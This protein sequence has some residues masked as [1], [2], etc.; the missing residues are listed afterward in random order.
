M[1]RGYITEWELSRQAGGLLS[2]EGDVV[3]GVGSQVNRNLAVRYR[4]RLPGTTRSVANETDLFERNLEAEY[5]LSRFFSV[6]SE[7]IQRRSTGTTSSTATPDFNVN[8]K[9]R[10]E[11]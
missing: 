8:L 1:F 4:Q 9:A 10:W 5:R 6:T 2:G 7:L 11:Y 3:V